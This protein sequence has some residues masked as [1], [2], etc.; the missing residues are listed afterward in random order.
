VLTLVTPMLLAL[1]PRETTAWQ[2]ASVRL[3]SS[4]P[5][6]TLMEERYLDNPFATH[7]VVFALAPVP[8]TLVALLTRIAKLTDPAYPAPATTVTVVSLTGVRSLVNPSANLTASAVLA[9]ATATAQLLLPTVASMDN[10][11]IVLFPGTH[12]AFRM[13]LLVGQAKANNVVTK[14]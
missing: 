6:A 10:V 9:L 7:L 1:V 2:T 12:V 4:M 3:V 5:T 11:I 14:R 8:L 13:D